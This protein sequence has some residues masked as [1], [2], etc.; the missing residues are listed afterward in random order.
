M[1]AL[2][3]RFSDES[4]K[5]LWNHLLYILPALAHLGELGGAS[6]LYGNCIGCG[7]LS[8]DQN[9]RFNLSKTSFLVFW[10]LSGLVLE[11]PL[12]MCGRSPE[13][14]SGCLALAFG[15]SKFGNSA[16]WFIWKFGQRDLHV[17]LRMHTISIYFCLEGLGF[18]V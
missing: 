2:R 14:L 1:S 9:F 13:G 18:R 6:K 17:C 16:K 4:A 7:S 3:V 15:R 11:L 10:F 12:P 5:L 8:Y